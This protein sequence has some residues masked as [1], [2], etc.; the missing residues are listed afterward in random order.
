MDESILS[1]GLNTA[2]IWLKELRRDLE[3]SD[4]DAYR[5]LRATLHQLRDN[6]P[7]EEATDLAAPLPLIFKGVYYDGYNPAGKPLRHDDLVFI[8]RVHS[9]FDNDP[10]IDPRELVRKVF[11]FLAAKLPQGQVKHVK[12]NLPQG[13]VSL[14]P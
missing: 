5:A 9:Q 6:L 11:A 14:W 8:S 2:E 12:D 7:V 13:L 4:Q 3:M 10:Q 1:A